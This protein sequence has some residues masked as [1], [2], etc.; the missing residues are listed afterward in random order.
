MRAVA[1]S[2]LTAR[3][4]LQSVTSLDRR[5]LTLSLA[6]IYAVSDIRG[7]FKKFIDRYS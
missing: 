3:V 7:A 4:A 6:F 1:L 5:M 2:K